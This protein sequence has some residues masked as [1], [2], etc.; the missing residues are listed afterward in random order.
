[1][2]A[3]ALHDV[4]DI[5]P[6]TRNMSVEPPSGAMGDVKHVTWGLCPSSQPYTDLSGAGAFLNA[7]S[8]R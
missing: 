5:G 4:A 1:M 6:L 7:C 8:S 3:V 2:E